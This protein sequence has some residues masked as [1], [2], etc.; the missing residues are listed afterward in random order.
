MKKILSIFIGLIILSQC[1]SALALENTKYWFPKGVVP[2]M[3][4]DLQMENYEIRNEEYLKTYHNMDSPFLQ[5]KIKE[6]KAQKRPLIQKDLNDANKDYQLLKNIA[7]SLNDGLGPT[8]ETYGSLDQNQEVQLRRI[9]NEYGDS[10][11]D[12]K[13]K[14]K[15]KRYRQRQAY[16]RTNNIN[17]T[18][19]QYQF[20]NMPNPQGRSDIE[21]FYNGFDYTPVIPS[22]ST[23][24]SNILQKG[25]NYL[26]GY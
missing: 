3:L 12:D 1:N 21:R 5:Q 9:L 20:T 23:I 11:L 19:N 18:G 13:F 22:A 16:L 4:D 2:Y 10:V 25:V 8:G 17:Q 6:A 7:G 26:L 14:S 15:L 24:K